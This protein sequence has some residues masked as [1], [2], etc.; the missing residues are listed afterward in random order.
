MYSC[1]QPAECFNTPPNVYIWALAGLETFRNTLH[2]FSKYFFLKNC[3]TTTCPLA[4]PHSG[5]KCRDVLENWC[6]K[7]D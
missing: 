7:I 4:P 5:E 2:L 1:T 6:M 3:N